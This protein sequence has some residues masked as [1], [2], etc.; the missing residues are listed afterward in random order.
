M[1][2]DERVI[3]FYESCSLDTIANALKMFKVRKFI[4][5]ILIK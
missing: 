2:F 5:A 4:I 3:E 1:L